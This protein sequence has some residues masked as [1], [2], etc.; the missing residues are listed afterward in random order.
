MITVIDS[1]GWL[2][3][4]ACVLALYL[5]AVLLLS[6]QGTPRH[7]RLGRYYFV[8]MLVV[9]LSALLIYRM[10]VFFFPHWLAIITLLV[11]AVGYWVIIQKPFKRWLGIHIF[12]VITSYY[13]LIGGA[14]NEAFLRLDYVI[15]IAERTDG[16]A[17]NTAHTIGMCVYGLMLVY[18]CYFG[19]FSKKHSKYLAVRKSNVGV[20][21]E[22]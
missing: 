9:N 21:G 13:M 8:S 11:L 16:L 4:F 3:T 19:R 18:Y 22:R 5:G 12:C 20:S 17:Y 2:H 7:R 6:V 15:A 14:I 1:V 10:N